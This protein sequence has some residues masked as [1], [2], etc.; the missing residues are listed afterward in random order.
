VQQCVREITEEKNFSEE[1]ILNAH[2]DLQPELGEEL[3]RLRLFGAAYQQAMRKSQGAPALRLRCPHCH[4]PSDIPSDSSLSD[5]TCSSCGQVFSLVE[6]QADEESL[7]PIQSLA[8]FQIL[9]R[10][11]AGGFG[12]VYQARDTQLDRIVAIKIPRRQNLSA[13]EA[14]QFF[15]E[16]RAS[17]Q[18]RHPNIVSIHEVGKDGEIIYIVSDFVQ[19]QSLAHWLK[20]QQMSL[21]EA[22]KLCRKIALAL[23]HAHEA[24]I[25]HRDLKPANILLD[26]ANE[27]YITDF[28]LAR[29]ESGEVTVTLDGQM[30]GTPAYMSPEQAR[31][32][33]HNSDRRSDVYCL[34]VILFELLTGELPFRG[35]VR[36]LAQQIVNDEPPSPRK[37]NITVSKDLETICLKCLQKDP[38]GRYA[39]ALELAEDLDRYL[40]H[41]PILARPISRL[42]RTW[43][44]CARKPAWAGLIAA[45]FVI[46]VAAPLLT[47][48]EAA[49]RRAAEA[50]SKVRYRKLY[51][52]DMHRAADALHDANMG[53]VL[54]L[55][56]RHKPEPGRDDLRGFEWNYLWQQC[57]RGATATTLQ[58]NDAV[59]RVALSPDGRTLASTTV[60]KGMIYF[61]DLAT[62]NQTHSFRAPNWLRGFAFSP[63]GKTLAT[64]DGTGS[65][66][67]LWDVATGTKIRS[68]IGHT[69]WIRCV[70]FSPDGKI[71]A[72]VG[73][74]GWL[75]LW[76][77][78]TGEYLRGVH[79]H[80]GN[81]RNVAFS[82]DGGSVA[83]AGY[84]PPDPAIR[85]AGNLI[86]RDVATLSQERCFTPQNQ[87]VS[88]ISCIAYSPDGKLLAAGCMDGLVRIWNANTTQE[89]LPYVAHEGQIHFIVFSLDSKLLATASEDKTVRLWEVATGRRVDTLKGHSGP[90]QCVAFTPDGQT[91][92]SAS[93]DRTVKL[94]DLRQHGESATVLKHV[95]WI[96]QIAFSAT[97]E[98][99]ASH[100]ADGNLYIWNVADGSKRRIIQARL[101]NLGSGSVAW[102]PDGKI[103]AAGGSGRP[104]M[105]WDAVT[106]AE[107]RTLQGRKGELAIAFSPDSRI[108]AT[109]EEGDQ[110]QLWDVATGRKGMD[111]R[112]HTAAI[113]TI[114]FSPDGTLLVT[115][116]FDRTVR[117]WNPATGQAMGAPQVYG[118]VVSQVALA[119]NGRLLAVATYDGEI[120]LREVATGKLVMTLLGHQDSA[121]SIAFSPDGKM[122]AS[123]SDDN[124]VR[125]WDLA[126][127]EERVILR[128]HTWRVNSVAFSRDGKTLASGSTD[129]T[130]RL[131]RTEN[132]IIPGIRSQFTSP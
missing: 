56:Q 21:R 97:G 58:H 65:K 40:K 111:L 125:L 47:L 130:I 124:T 108:L 103:L 64:G 16:A 119:P 34:G 2:P 127:G 82:P 26:E 8:H 45:L 52:A 83:V 112:G 12:T 60:E 121:N 77:P 1:S 59:L 118:G 79:S 20:S 73:D 74:D 13:L 23:H 98:Q 33:A 85:L 36:M 38:G 32:E 91:L 76:N 116:G 120:C 131:W 48:R 24:G 114:A 95:G 43:R 88:P 4:V 101:G 41:E 106:G 39:T 86:V 78:A 75:K 54:E 53:L 113:I 87:D 71:L 69:N 15:R 37:F 107:V 46:F 84:N 61:W 29:R 62:G 128:G 117:L 51:F 17:A 14:E 80:S 93:S 22:A 105:L 10:Q 104:V 67:H 102:S 72:S 68:L 35:T 11:G 44:W 49:S 96:N 89:H 63:D 28:G 92:A 115:G 123:G 129:G 126:S 109:C 100:C 9:Q 5:V 7:P 99:V 122:L 132:V 19:G 94:W 66:V 3:R 50:E 70:A 30:V 42:E 25:I 31:G 57:Q 6:D 55:L 27:P 90:V 81:A 110:V 18:L